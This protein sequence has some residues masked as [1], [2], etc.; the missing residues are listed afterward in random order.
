MKR[1]IK[2]L[3]WGVK[4]LR[5]DGSDNATNF[6]YLTNKNR[7]LARPSRAVIIFVHFF[8]VLGNLRLKMTISQVIKRT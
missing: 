3:D 1:C 4:D 5:R 6:A 7:T 8:P 2:Y